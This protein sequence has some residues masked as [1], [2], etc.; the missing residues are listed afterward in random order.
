MLIL[1]RKKGESVAI[2]ENIRIKVLSVKGSQVRL[3]VDAPGKVNVNREE[4]QID[5]EN[6]GSV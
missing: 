4:Q 6:T 5:V 2:G 3:G 1:T